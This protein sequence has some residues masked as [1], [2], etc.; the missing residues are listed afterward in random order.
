MPQNGDQKINAEV[1]ESSGLGMWIKDWGWGGKDVLK[2]EE[3]GKAIEEMMGDED[4]KTNAA[5]VKQ[6]ARKAA[7]GGGSC[8]LTFERLIQECKKQDAA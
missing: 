1:V 6:A 7:S 8:Q 5:K 2:G 3:I 4:L